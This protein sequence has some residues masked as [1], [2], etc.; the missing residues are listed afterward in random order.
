MRDAEVLEMLATLL[1]ELG[2]TGWK[3]L[4]NTVGSATDRPRYVQTLREAL[5][6]VA[7]RMCEDCQRRAADQPAA[8]ARLQAS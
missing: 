5:E 3:L 7:A 4:I 8:R 1:S 2:I 6:P